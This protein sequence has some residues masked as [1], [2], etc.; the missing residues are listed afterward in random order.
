MDFYNYKTREF[1]PIDLNKIDYTREELENYLLEGN[2]IRI[3]YVG[4]GEEK[5]N[6]I[7]PMISIVGGKD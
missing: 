6:I 7:L 2:R 5:E 1:V 3:R 4:T